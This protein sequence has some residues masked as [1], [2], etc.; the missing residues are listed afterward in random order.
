MPFSTGRGQDGGKEGGGALFPGEC[1]LKEEA[2]VTLLYLSPLCGEVLLK[3]KKCKQK[4]K[5]FYLC[6]KRNLLLPEHL[7]GEMSLKETTTEESSPLDSRSLS[8][9][10]D[11][12]LYHQG[13]IKKKD[14]VAPA[15]EQVS[16]YRGRG[17]LPYF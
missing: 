8:P 4:R 9:F 7:G 15:G 13:S 11:G 16:L 12:G 10:H 17:G 5:D 3:W 6:S 2:A 1:A 14:G